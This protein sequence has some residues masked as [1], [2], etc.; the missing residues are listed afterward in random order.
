M[1]Q[2]RRSFIKKSGLAVA[3]LSLASSKAFS[4]SNS[5]TL[6][7][8]LYSV[9]D[10]M[11]ANPLQTL[12]QIA[13]IGYKYVEH[14][15]YVERKFYGFTA[16]EFKKIL[17]DLDLKMPSGHTVLNLKQHWDESKNDFTD[18]WKYL[19]E[20]AAVVGQE[21]VIS[22]S[23]VSNDFPTLDS[24]KHLFDVFNKSGELCK[25]SGMKFGYHN[26]DFEFS[27]KIGDKTLYD[28]ILENTDSR[29]VAQQL[30]TGNLFNGGAKAFDIVKKYPDRFELLHVKDEIET[31]NDKEKYESTVLGTGVAQLKDVLKN[32]T[33]TKIFVVEQEAYQGKAPIVCAKEDFEIMKSWGF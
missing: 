7:I 18:L 32:S 19:V 25:K 20:D 4:F 15:N 8:Q 5:K 27:R 21:Y 30:D 33:A 2:S 3:G 17:T 22:P 12:Q 14:A 1:I 24:L 11:K 16:K 9:R 31:K 6:A 28:L 26:H 23:F 10:E 13:K 29:L